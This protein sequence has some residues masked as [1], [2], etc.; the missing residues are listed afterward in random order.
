MFIY[1]MIILLYTHQIF[2]M[3]TTF[4][5]FGLINPQLESIN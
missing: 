1:R 3:Y 4:R 2:E 5:L